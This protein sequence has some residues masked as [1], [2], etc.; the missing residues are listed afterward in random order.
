M[1][2]VR[3][4]LFK[5]HGA[6]DAFCVTTNGYIRRDG[7]AVMGRGI[8]LEI[9]KKSPMI[10]K[11]LG[12]GIEENGN[13]VQSIG[14][15]EGTPVIAFPVKPEETIVLPG[16]TNIV[17]HVRRLVKEGNRV[18]GWCSVAELD[19]IE[20][21][22]KQLSKLADD[23]GYTSVLLPRPGCG[24]GELSYSEASPV[25]EKRLDDRFYIVTY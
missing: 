4:D 10:D 19:I 16:K 20:E 15:Y 13:V 11:R 18:P 17:K 14:T 6:Y 8:A 9:K 2:D 5:L 25:L 12:E 1:K 21:S 24:A 3:G 22:C 7:R 23:L